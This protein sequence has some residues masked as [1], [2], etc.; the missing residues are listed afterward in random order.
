MDFSSFDQ[1]SRVAP[2]RI[3]SRIFTHESLRSSRYIHACHIV[4][5]PLGLL[6]EAESITF[7][8][9]KVQCCGRHVHS[10]TWGH[11]KNRHRLLKQ[12]R[13]N[14]LFNQTKPWEPRL[15]NGYPT[16]LKKTRT[17]GRLPT[18]VFMGIVSMAVAHNCCCTPIR[19]TASIGTSNG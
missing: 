16:L 2:H 5:W 19:P 1:K 13:S 14:P 18:N 4:T 6:V 11:L 17:T 3:L 12:H 8:K 9:V 10:T 15:D 7:D